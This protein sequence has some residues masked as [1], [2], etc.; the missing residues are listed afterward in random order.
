MINFVYNPLTSCLAAFSEKLQNLSLKSFQFLPISR[1]AHSAQSAERE[2]VTLEVFL[3]LV[4]F[5]QKR[6]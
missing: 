2:E 4:Y 3:E 1:L 5:R 6:Q